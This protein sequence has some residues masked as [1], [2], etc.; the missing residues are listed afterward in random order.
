VRG[1]HRVRTLLVALLVT[2]VSVACLGLGWWQWQRFGLTGSAQNLGYTLQWPLFALFPI[3]AWW[4]LSKLHAQ[5]R[6]RAAETAAAPAEHT[7]PAGQ[8]KPPPAS[9]ASRWAA[10]RP[11]RPAD[12]EPDDELAAYNRYLAELNAQAKESD[13][14]R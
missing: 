14:A 8:P 13:R 3:I 5:R 4:R 7:A 11:A 12:G 9:A 6:Q 2:A 1:G 10:P